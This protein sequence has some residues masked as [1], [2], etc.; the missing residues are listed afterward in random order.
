MRKF[1]NK[2]NKGITEYDVISLV[3]KTLKSI[4]NEESNSK[5][6]NGR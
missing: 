1:K 2:K 5:H 4:L 6:K 3:Q